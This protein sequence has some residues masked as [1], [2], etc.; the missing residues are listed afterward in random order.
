M[1]RKLSGFLKLADGLDLFIVFGAVNSPVVQNT[2]RRSKSVY[3]GYVTSTRIEHNKKL[4]RE[5]GY[6]RYFS[7]T[8]LV[9]S[10]FIS[11]FVSS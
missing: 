6:F 11:G 2:T 10:V 7:T 3:S 4:I 9:I 5:S 1:N 8:V